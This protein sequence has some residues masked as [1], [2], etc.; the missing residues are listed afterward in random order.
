MDKTAP[1]RR[2]TTPEI[3]TRNHPLVFDLQVVESA[4]DTM[5]IDKDNDTTPRKIAMN[6]KASLENFFL[7][8]PDDIKK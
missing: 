2:T 5:L 3:A 8:V 4:A 1:L 7:S 6:A